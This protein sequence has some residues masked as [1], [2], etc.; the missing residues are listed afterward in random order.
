MIDA[1]VTC[2]NASFGYDGHI[3][4]HN[5]TFS[6]EQGDYLCIVGENGSGKS[7]LIKGIVRLITPLQGSIVIN[8]GGMAEGKAAPRAMRRSAVGYLSQAAAAKKDFPAGVAEIVF[9]GMTGGMGLRPF[10]SRQEKELAEKTMRRLAITALRNRC[11][12]ELSGGQQR[13]V[14]IAR[15]LCAVLRDDPAGEDNAR[16]NMLVLDEPAAGL[17]PLVTAEVYELLQTLNAELGI[18]II[19]VSHDIDSALQ[20]A[21]HILHITAAGSFYGTQDEYTRS[22][23]YK[24]LIGGTRDA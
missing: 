12:R 2:Q 9:S 22:H 5:L 13:R 3:V 21:R 23:H 20:Y 4:V 6:V 7:T 24:H 8:A 19:M 14:L 16:R 11:F 15:A 10:Y 17:D 1:I 18:A